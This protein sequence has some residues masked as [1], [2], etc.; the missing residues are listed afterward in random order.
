MRD[1]SLHILCGLQD[2][3]NTESRH[4]EIGRSREKGMN[5]FA[6][7]YWILWSESSH[8]FEQG[9]QGEPES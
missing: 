6:E 8:S 9:E 5:W 4:A 3:R 1:F 7:F 2:A